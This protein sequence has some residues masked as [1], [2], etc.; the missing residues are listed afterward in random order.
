[1]DATDLIQR[2]PEWFSVRLGCV[3]SSVVGKAA[4][5]LKRSNE[6]TQAALDL[7]YELAA[8]RITGV[9]A[10]RGNALAWGLAHEDEARG[11]YAFLSNAEI[12]QVGF[13]PHPIIEN[14]GCSPDALVGDDGALEIK[15]PTSATHLQ[16]L[17]ADAVPEEHLPQL[18]WVLACAGREWID[19][20]SFDPRFPPDMRLFVKRVERD[21]EKIAALEAEAIAFLAELDGKLAALR[22]RYPE[23]EWRSLGAVALEVEQHL[24]GR[25]NA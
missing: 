20:V 13:V 10:K 2:S 22:E 7:M 18:H 8:E 11:A 1:M 4:G 17:L 14:A 23:A 9:P 16:T 15:A 25:I 12:K 21:D 24:K 5:R 3:T 6:R 19:F